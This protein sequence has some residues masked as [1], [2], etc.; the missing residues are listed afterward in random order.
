MPV[1]MN[2]SRPCYRR[3]DYL[4]LALTQDPAKMVTTSH[5]FIYLCTRIW[6]SQ[7]VWDKSSSKFSK[8]SKKMSALN[9]E[10]FEKSLLG[11]I[12]SQFLYILSLNCTGKG[13]SNKSLGPRILEWMVSLQ[14]RL[15]I[16]KSNA[17]LI[18]AINFYFLEF[19]R[20]GCRNP[21]LRWNL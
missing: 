17:S 21:T 2:S 7:N 13:S 11:V 3:G 8:C 4:N 1:T 19:C 15:N 12:Q 14:R 20:Q 5:P 16:H 6:V 18:L 9:Y 10:Q